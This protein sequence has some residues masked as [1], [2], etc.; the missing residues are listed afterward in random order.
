MI[1]IMVERDLGPYLAAWRARFRESDAERTRRAREARRL[2]PLL[3]ERLVKGYGARRVWL[4]G[5]LVEGGFDERSDIDLAAEGLPP[6][7]ALFRAGAELDDLARPFTVDLIPIEEARP[8]VREK[9][10]ARGELLHGRE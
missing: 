7:S 2:A 3:A 4:I 9:V 6:G 1:S 5:S 8:S 10:F